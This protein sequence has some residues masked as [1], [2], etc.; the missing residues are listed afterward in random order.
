MVNGRLD[1]NMKAMLPSEICISGGG[2]AV[3]AR[4]S[5]YATPWGTT[6]FWLDEVAGCGLDMLE[7]R[8]T[9]AFKGNAAGHEFV[10]A[11]AVVSVD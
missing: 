9:S 11:T 3:A 10:G 2:A 4:N 7:Y 6:F 1:S 5:E 8:L